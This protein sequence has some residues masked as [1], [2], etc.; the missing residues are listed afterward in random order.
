[1]E[2]KRVSWIKC[3]LVLSTLLAAAIILALAVGPV[4]IRPHR[5]ASLLTGAEATASEHAIVF[6]VRLPR[7]V[8]GIV[9]GG[10]LS[11]AGLSLLL[12]LVLGRRSGC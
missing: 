5:L 1:M 4:P 11:V 10:A 7:I 2:P 8:L 12:L 3:L 9:V 6:S